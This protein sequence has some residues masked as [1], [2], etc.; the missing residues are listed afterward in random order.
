[1]YICPA[2]R[3]AAKAQGNLPWLEEQLADPSKLKRV[4][5]AYRLKCFDALLQIET[6][7]MEVSHC[8][9]R[10][11]VALRVLDVGFKF[12]PHCLLVSFCRQIGHPTNS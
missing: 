2:R 1:M 12:Q 5:A 10:A 9:G 4:V 3:Y 8:S 6:R 11:P 7:G